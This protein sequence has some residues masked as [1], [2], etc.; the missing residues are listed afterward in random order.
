MYESTL[1]K[2]LISQPEIDYVECFNSPDP[3]AYLIEHR[4]T[5]IIDWNHI[6]EKYKLNLDFMSDT[7]FQTKLNWKKIPIAQ[8]NLSTGFIKFAQKHNIDNN[9]IAKWQKL[10]EDKIDDLENILDFDIIAAHQDISLAYIKANITKFKDFNLLI[11]NS[12][13]LDLEFINN[14]I[15]KID[16]KLLSRY[17][18][19]DHD[20]I[21]NNIDK[22]DIELLLKY[23]E[24]EINTINYIINLNN[25]IDNKV[26][27]TEENNTYTLVR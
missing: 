19:L 15:S 12:N 11:I 16:F 10:D 13:N 7:T 25:N 24:L 27:N 22:L 23:Q 6:T 18:Y 21:I 3:K 17:Q 1:E 14:N 8:D 2:D 20:F 9:A 4:D 26:S 5:H